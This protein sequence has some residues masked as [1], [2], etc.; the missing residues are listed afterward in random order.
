M[1]GMI[2]KSLLVLTCHSRQILIKL[3]LFHAD[4]LTDWRTDRHDNANSCFSQS[5]ER[6]YKRSQ[7]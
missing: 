1:S 6:A 4:G 5:C 3:E 7:I 2:P